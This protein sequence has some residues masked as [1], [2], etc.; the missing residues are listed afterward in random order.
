MTAERARYAGERV[1]VSGWLVVVLVALAAELAIPGLNL[2]DTVARPSQALTTLVSELRAGP[3]RDEIGA[4]LSA[5][6]QGLA[7]AIAV[8]VVAGVAI[9]S[10]R[11]LLETSSGVIEFLRPVPAVALIPLA[12]YALGFDTEMRRF[13]VAYAAVWPILFNTLYGVRGV[14]RMLYD[15][16]RTS[17]ASRLGV[18]VRVTLPASLPSIATGIRISAS[19]ALLVCVTVEYWTQTA[20]LGAYMHEQYGAI[21]YDEVYAAVLLTA[22]IG[23]V[24]NVVLRSTERRALFWVG[25]ERRAA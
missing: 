3:L 4:T 8:G 16:A 11:T 12:T 13:L 9:G 21:R 22:L 10:S 24:V 19:L 14:D 20:G 18:L 6:L 1:N 7:I 25:E 23:Y 17:G 5:Y 15:V 2:E